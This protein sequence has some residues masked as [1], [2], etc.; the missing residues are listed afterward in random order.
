MRLLCSSLV[1]CLVLNG[2]ASVAAPTHD[3][4]LA[5]VREVTDGDTLVLDRRISDAI[6]VRLV[7]IQAPKLARPN[8]NIQAW[9][10][11]EE[12]KQALAELSLGRSVRLV[13]GKYGIDRHGRL[14]AHVLREDGLWLQGEMLRRGMARVYT[15]GDNRA[16]AREMLTLEQEARAA[17]RGIWIH[18]FYAV[19]SSDA[20]ASHADGFQL[21]E[22]R[23]LRA[24][25]VGNRVF[26]NFG[27]DWKTD[28]TVAVQRQLVPLFDEVDLDLL[29]LSGR[30]VRVRG[31]V[32]WENGPMIAVDHPE[33][34]ELP[35]D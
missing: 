20:V 14:L 28:F 19:R 17:G 5:N 3:D 23:V 32:L 22:G 1:V 25:A 13:V 2:T 6:E 7:G 15:F 31:W 9:P 8:R 26:L 21:V 30:R 34:I 4:H 24:A 18:P 35:D 16:R 11:A 33:Q 10:S 29:G 27:P 12:A